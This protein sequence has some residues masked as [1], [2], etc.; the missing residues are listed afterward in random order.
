MIVLHRIYTK[1]TN[2]VKFPTYTLIISVNVKLCYLH[3]KI[4]T[5]SHYSLC[6]STIAS[7]GGPFLCSNKGPTLIQELSPAYLRA[8]VGNSVTWSCEAVGESLPKYRWSKDYKV[9]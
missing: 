4:V 6:A 9:T 5:C 3:K 1:N 7:A 2:L 8:R